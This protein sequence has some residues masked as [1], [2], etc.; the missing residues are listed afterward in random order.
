M[1][2]KDTSVEV[3]PI[4]NASNYSIKLDYRTVVNKFPEF[5]E[6]IDFILQSEGRADLIK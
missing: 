1:V 6:D 3:N 5:K 2:I 4:E